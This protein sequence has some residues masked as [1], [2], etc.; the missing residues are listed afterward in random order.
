M[1]LG[2]WKEPR[3]LHGRAV[4]L[5]R[6]YWRLSRRNGYAFMSQ[7]E[8]AKELVCS[9]ASIGIWTKELLDAGIISPRDTNLYEVNEYMVHLDPRHWTELRKVLDQELKFSNGQALNFKDCRVQ[10]LAPLIIKFRDQQA[11]TFRHKKEDQAGSEAGSRNE[12]SLAG[13]EMPN[14]AP[15]MNA[16]QTYQLKV[17]E[18]DVTAWIKAGHSVQAIYDAVRGTK[19][20]VRSHVAYIQTI[21]SQASLRGAGGKVANAVTSTRK[22]KFIEN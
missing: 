16:I 5:W 20:D 18:R 21:L 7:K 3:V 11:L 19:T 12:E 14:L 8:M 4:E 1:S 10:I 13:S 22:P 2:T 17:T 6:L 9:P 15:I